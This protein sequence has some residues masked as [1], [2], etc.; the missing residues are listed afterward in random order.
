MMTPCTDPLAHLPIQ[1]CYLLSLPQ[2]PEPHS[3]TRSQTVGQGAARPSAEPSQQS[4][5]SHSDARR[6]KPVPHPHS[7]KAPVAGCP[8]CGAKGNTR[9]SIEITPT[10]RELYYRCSDVMC[11]MTWVA[12]LSFERMLSPSGLGDTFRT[13]EDKGALPPGHAFGQQLA[14]M[15]PGSPSG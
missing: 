12:S 5:L 13:A 10:F 8:V 15:P 3:S 6:A 4:D 7:G 1:G 11:G 14:D 2:N 9:S